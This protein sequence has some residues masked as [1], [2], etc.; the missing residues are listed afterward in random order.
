MYM[1]VTSIMY[2]FLCENLKEIHFIAPRDFIE[3]ALDIA[4]H[5]GFKNRESIIWWLQYYMCTSGYIE[6]KASLETITRW[7][8]HVYNDR[9]CQHGD[10]H[11]SGCDAHHTKLLWNNP[12]VRIRY[13]EFHFFVQRMWIGDREKLP[14]VFYRKDSSVHGFLRI[15]IVFVRLL[16]ILNLYHICLYSLIIHLVK[17]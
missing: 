13:Q 11:L 7:I 5:C 12:L 14:I 2:I 1:H 9:M 4:C 8:C 16:L 6:D 15:K 17:S 3:F 10:T